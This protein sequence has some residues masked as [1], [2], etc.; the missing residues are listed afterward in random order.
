M[1]KGKIVDVGDVVDNLGWI[2][3]KQAFMAHAV[4]MELQGLDES[5]PGQA[6]RN[7]CYAIMAGL[8][9]ETKAISDKLAAHIPLKLAS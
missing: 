9:D 7:G 3:D 8:A 5:I 2:A 4:S 6:I 1:G